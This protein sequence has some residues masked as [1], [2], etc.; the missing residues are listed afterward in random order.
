MN[1][2]LALSSACLALAVGVTACQGEPNTIT[3]GGDT[4][5][6]QAEATSVTPTPTVTPPATPTPTVKL[7]GAFGDTITFPSGVAVKVSQ[8][9]AVAAD[10]Y[11]YNAVEGRIVVVEIAVTNGSKEPLD[12]SLMGYPTVRYSAKGIEARSA[13]DATIGSD[14][15]STILPGE[16]QTVKEGYG[17]PA[18]GFADVR[19]EIRGPSLEDRPAIFKGAVKK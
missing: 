13:N 15:F 10:Q 17:I 12:G 19:V 14:S 11:A 9:V 6:A 2:K 4:P 16:T 7:S 8:P 1:R 3:E 5:T 18:A